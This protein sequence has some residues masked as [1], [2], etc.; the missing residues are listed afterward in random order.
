MSYVSKT[1]FNPRFQ[2][3]AE[4]AAQCGSAA[5]KEGDS[6]NE[7]HSQSETLDETILKAVSRIVFLLN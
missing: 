2:P 1:L 3:E 6:P 5:S 4:N 7:G